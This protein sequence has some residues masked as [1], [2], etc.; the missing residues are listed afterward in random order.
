MR[1]RQLLTMAASLPLMATGSSIA[2]AA[3]AANLWDR[4]TAHDPQS[5]KAVD[6]TRWNRFLAR[7]VATSQDG[8]NR[9]AYQAIRIADREMLKSY[10]ADL[11]MVRAT[12]LA[13]DEQFA[14]WVNLYNALTIDVVLEHYPVDSIRDID[15]SPGLFADG[16]WGKALIEVEDVPVSLD[17]IEH[18][19]LRPIWRDPRIHYAVN[20][21]ATG[22]PNLA[23]MAYTASSIERLLAEGA[24]A[25]VNHDRGCRIEDG[26]LRVS[27]IYRWFAED[28][29]G[30]DAGV[31]AH[32]RQHAKGSRIPM[33]E[34]ISRIAGHS[35]D[36][37]LNEKAPMPI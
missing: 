23:P 20:C 7:Y 30:K 19:I 17:D 9:I 5:R 33:L 6:H 13:R 22:C 28:F 25:F 8:I 35:Y 1:R 21:A 29:G 26:E 2:A 10:L 31:I 16:P 14:Y 3:P 11:A 15:I 34:S 37:R 32:L 18:R 4:W 36:W 24:S 12:M 27:S